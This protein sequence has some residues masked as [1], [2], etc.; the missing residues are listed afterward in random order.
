MIQIV[1]RRDFIKKSGLLAASVGL[2]QLLSSQGSGS[3]ARKDPA[4]KISLA[5]WSLHRT[6]FAG[7]LNNLDFAQTARKDY[8]IEAVEYVNQFFKDKAKD[9]A[10]LKD[11]KK[12]ASDHDVKSVLIMID[13]E[14]ALGDPDEAKRKQAVENHHQW[15]DAAKYLDCHSIR[16]NAY[17]TGTYDEQMKLAADGLRR[18]TEYGA[19]QGINI[20]V[21]NH[22]GFSSNGTW[23]AAVIKQVNHPRCGT[24]PDFGNFDLGEGKM[25]DRYKGVQEMMPFAKG[26]SAKSHDFDEAGNETNT[27][28]K[29]MMKIV[30]DAGYRGYV[31]VEYEGDKSSEP[32]GD[33]RDEEVA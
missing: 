26:V 5:Q 17:S 27:D 16:V 14:G 10:Y 19:G 1:D 23:L 3:A 6:I 18:L 22:G 11:M 31:G 12:R 30:F 8:G 25:Y 9:T 13:D 2:P 15:V 28:Y 7:K 4:F 24:L 20:I 29:R 33:S 21:E 32:E